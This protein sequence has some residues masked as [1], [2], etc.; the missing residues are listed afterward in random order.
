VTEV[1]EVTNASG[2]PARYTFNNPRDGWVFLSLKTETKGNGSVKISLDS[3]SAD[4]AVIVSTGRDTKP[5]EAM[6]HLSAGEH[7]LVCFCDKDAEIEKLIVRAIPELIY[8]TFGHGAL[9]TEHGPY[10]WDFLEE[11][12]LRNVNA[13]VTWIDPPVPDFLITDWKRQ[14]KKW[15]GTCSIPGRL[16]RPDTDASNSYS[17]WKALFDEYD[18]LDGII[19]DEFGPDMEEEPNY[20]GQYDCWKEALEKIHAQ[21]KY[22]NK[23]FYAYIY[24]VNP[25]PSSTPR[26]IM[27]D[28]EHAKSFIKTLMDCDY[29]LSW[30]RYFPELAT[31]EAARDTLDLWLKKPM[32]KWRESQPGIEKYMILC[33]G[34]FSTP[35]LSMNKNPGVNYKV[36]IEKQYNMAANDPAF[37][38]IAGIMYWT[39]GYA[40]EETN[41]WIGKLF[42]HYC[43]EGRTDMLSED[44]YILTHIRN[45]DF[46]EGDRSWSLSPAEEGSIK[47]SSREDYG[48]L[49]GRYYTFETEGDSF[50]LMKRSSKGPNTFS[51]EIRN[52]QPEREYSVKLI[53]GDFN[54]LERKS[55]TKQHHA[56]SIRVEGANVKKDTYFQHATSSQRPWEGYF[57]NYHWFVFRAKGETARLIIADW[58]SREDPGGPIGQ[59]L[60]YN[61]I[62]VQPYLSR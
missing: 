55:S 33:F 1:L 31:E 43:I 57:T 38:G 41:R 20:N 13:I 58:E 56:V 32:L 4:D 2:S 5:V 59:E 44:P 9:I 50:L 36:W 8:S 30:E 17:Y 29:F 45:P 3:E 61:F 21:E 34:L 26:Y 22:S 60:M 24:R 27:S 15:I 18:Y 10:D 54:D 12:I 42:R 19:A 62:E 52:L 49:Q 47:V 39:S 25:P 46:V 28:R 35:P 11:H 53:T 23:K 7:T 37:S 40:D 14:G 6:R 48:K 16:D 51:Q